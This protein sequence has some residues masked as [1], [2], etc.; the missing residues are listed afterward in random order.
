MIEVVACH[1]LLDGET[2]IVVDRFGR[3]TVHVAPGLGRIGDLVTKLP[4]G[5]AGVSPTCHQLALAGTDGRV[6]LVAIEGL[7]NATLHITALQSLQRRAK[8]LQKLFG[9]TSLT[10][11]YTC[12]CPACRSSL[13]LSA[14][15]PG[16]TMKCP[17]CKRSLRIVC[18]A[19]LTGEKD[20]K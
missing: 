9:G 20:K 8:G 14:A 10:Y 4:S 17:S 11:T 12:V 1:F 13:A 19:M 15:T 5:A 18:I 7:E 16:Q 2:L 3:I 6:R